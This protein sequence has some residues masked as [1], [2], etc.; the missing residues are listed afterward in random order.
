MTQQEFELCH[1]ERGPHSLNHCTIRTSFWNK[2]ENSL[3]RLL[4]SSFKTILIL[5]H[6]WGVQIQTLKKIKQIEADTAEIITYDLS[7]DKQK[8]VKWELNPMSVLRKKAKICFPSSWGDYMGLHCMALS[9]Q[10]G[11]NTGH[12]VWFKPMLSNFWTETPKNIPNLVNNS[13]PLIRQPMGFIG[14]RIHEEKK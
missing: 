2:V 6:F 8:T 4:S 9:W 10:K 1:T 12:M 5:K 14:N 11:S 3:Q 13:K 7:W